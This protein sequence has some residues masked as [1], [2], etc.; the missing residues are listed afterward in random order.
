VKRNLRVISVQ[1]DISSSKSSSSQHSYMSLNSVMSLSNSIRPYP[2]ADLGILANTFP[3]FFSKLFAKVII[4]STALLF[5]E[6][7]LF[8]GIAL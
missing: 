3:Q 7:L 4:A 1:F 8:T 2:K 5:V 6:T